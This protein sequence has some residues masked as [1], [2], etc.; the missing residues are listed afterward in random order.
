MKRKMRNRFLILLTDKER[1]ENRR[2]KQNE[3]ADAIGISPHT[4]KSWVQNDVTKYEAPI[5][6][7]ICDYFDCDLTDLLYFEMVEE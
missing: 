2:I 7:R 6:E 1:R 5:V 3:I 4:V